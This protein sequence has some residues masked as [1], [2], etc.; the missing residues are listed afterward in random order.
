MIFQPRWRNRAVVCVLA[1][2]ESRTG[3][4]L[5]EAAKSHSHLA[6]VL[7]LSDPL[8]QSPDAP[9][10]TVKIVKPFG[11][12]ILVGAIQLAEA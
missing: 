4:Y 2:D 7:M 6:A 12:K 10:R 3:I 11:R 8:Q 9:E 5:D 1:P